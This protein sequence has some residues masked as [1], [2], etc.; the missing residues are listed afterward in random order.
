MDV[1]LILLVILLVV[2]LVV[3][4]YTLRWVRMRRSGGV[5]VALRWDPENAGAGWHLGVGRY[6]GER[7]AWYRVWSLRGGPS[8][9]LYRERLRIVERR[10]PVGTESYAVPAGSLVLCCSVAT[11]ESAATDRS[12][13]TG[14]SLEIAMGPDALTGFMSWLESAPPG[15]RLPR[16]G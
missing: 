10:E 12:A 13:G 6:M 9:V 14:E 8:R 1:S 4:W 5:N 15:R 16:A 11:G 2:V 7:F 3:V